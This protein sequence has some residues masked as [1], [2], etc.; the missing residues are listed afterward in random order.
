MAFSRREPV[1][2]EARVIVD[3]IRH[4]RVVLTGYKGKL[5]F[6]ISSKTGLVSG[7]SGFI[8]TQL[9]RFS[10]EEMDIFIEVETKSGHAS[11]SG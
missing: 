5:V 9:Y 4:Q 3:V 6:V 2:V 8:P 7:R 11:P 10:N 1:V